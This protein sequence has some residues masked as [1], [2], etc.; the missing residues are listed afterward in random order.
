MPSPHN[1]LSK[2]E[3]LKS[4]KVIEQIFR[5]GRSFQLFPFVVYYLPQPHADQ[6]LRAGFGVSSRNFKKAVNRNRVKRL[7]REAFRIQKHEL[8]AL[9]K[10]Q[11]KMLSVFFIYTGKELPE[12]EFVS[13]KIAAALQRLIKLTNETPDA[14]A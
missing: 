2:S 9:L 4:R 11:N 7:T 5:E 10:S 3:R 6:W 12:Q 13:K 8:E 14:S 1:T